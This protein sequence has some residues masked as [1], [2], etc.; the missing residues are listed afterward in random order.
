M[1]G[2]GGPAPIS[3]LSGRRLSVSPR[4]WSP[5]GSDS[6]SPVHSRRRLS[7]AAPSLSGLLSPRYTVG[8]GG[9]GSPS[10]SATG[11]QGDGG[12][13]GGRVTSRSL[14]PPTSPDHHNGPQQR[15][16]GRRKLRQQ[17]TEMG[18][19]GGGSSREGSPTQPDESR[20]GVRS[21][22]R[23]S[24]SMSWSAA[25]L[26][27]IMS[28]SST[29]S[30]GAAGAG[31]CPPPPPAAVPP[32]PGRS[33]DDRSLSP[34]LAITVMGAAAPAV[35]S[36][37]GSPPWEPAHGAAPAAAPAAPAASTLVSDGT[38]WTGGAAAVGAFPAG[39]LPIAADDNDGDDDDLGRATAGGAFGRTSP[40]PADRKGIRL[41]DAPAAGRSDGHSSLVSRGAASATPGDGVGAGDGD[42]NGEAEPL[43]SV[44]GSFQGAAFDAFGDCGMGDS[45]N[46]AAEQEERERE[47]GTGGGE[48][49]QVL[50][51]PEVGTRNID[52][53]LGIQVRRDTSIAGGVGQTRVVISAG[54]CSARRVTKRGS[55]GR[56]SKT[57]GVLKRKRTKNK[58]A[59]GAR[60]LAVARCRFSTTLHLVP[61]GPRRGV[62]VRGPQLPDRVVRRR[63]GGPPPRRVPAVPL[64]RRQ[65]PA[66]Q[67]EAGRRRLPGLPRGWGRVCLVFSRNVRCSGCDC[68]AQGW[69]A[70]K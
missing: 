30:V 33:D 58:S 6:A 50:G 43:S 49:T 68:T 25:S 65:R 57:A 11:G 27:S 3:P 31:P 44:M 13:G 21:G 1:R 5:S 4:R 24:I 48:P 22:R 67:R 26:S 17:V 38:A 10:S 29:S 60:T 28:Y 2:G 63:A 42:V 64:P 54:G 20:G 46:A 19:G 8:G 16:Q 14:S 36:S 55:T 32:A 59:S 39:G 40:P 18:G 70:S 12:G 47:R 51:V 9:G 61:S 62:L 69:W 15:R 23:K 56:K 35:C 45:K 7:M 52:E 41:E 53:F 66:Q 37:G 34:A